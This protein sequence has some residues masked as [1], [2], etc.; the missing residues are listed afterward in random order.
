MTTKRVAYTAQ[1]VADLLGMSRRQVYRWIAS[2]Q[3][4]VARLGRAI[5]ISDF[6]LKQLMKERKRRGTKA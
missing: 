6:R 1:E 3:L 5:R 4:P 2:G